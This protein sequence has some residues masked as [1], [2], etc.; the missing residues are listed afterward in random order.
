MDTDF[1]PYEREAMYKEIDDQSYT[2]SDKTLK[3][4]VLSSVVY[5]ARKDKNDKGSSYSGDR[6][7]EELRKNIIRFPH[8]RLDKLELVKSNQNMCS[9]VDRGT[10]DGFLVCR[11]TSPGFTNL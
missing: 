6:I 9:F 10:K 5:A 11:G 2:M 7:M 3:L 4:A 1:V 8:L